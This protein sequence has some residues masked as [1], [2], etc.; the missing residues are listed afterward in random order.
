MILLLF[1]LLLLML[2][3]VSV[4]VCNG[5]SSFSLRQMIAERH[6]SVSVYVSFGAAS[7]AAAATVAASLQSTLDAAHTQTET[8]RHSD[9]KM[10]RS[11]CTKMEA[12]KGSK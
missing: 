12:A 10:D 4:S 1:W 5:S 7:A 9:E 6:F 8:G 3:S 2:L 11:V